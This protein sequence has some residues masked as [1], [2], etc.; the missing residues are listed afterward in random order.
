MSPSLDIAA[1]E[2]DRQSSRAPG[3]GRPG[4]GVL[5]FALALGVHLAFL[6]IVIV[7]D[8]T[9]PEILGLGAATKLYPILFL[10]PLGVLCLRAG[11]LPTWLRTAGAAVATLILVNLPVY[12][13][14]GWFTAESGELDHRYLPEGG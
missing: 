12:L 13:L 11:R 7:D 2:T 3:Y 4:Q 10:V 9:S 8:W 1:I 6:A 14:A 5:A